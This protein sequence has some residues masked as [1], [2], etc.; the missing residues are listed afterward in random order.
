M[1]INAMAKSWWETNNQQIGALI[2]LHNNNIIIGKLSTI[3]SKV[4]FLEIFPKSSLE[5][6]RCTVIA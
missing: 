1:V 2:I 3:S 6:N 4:A 5:E